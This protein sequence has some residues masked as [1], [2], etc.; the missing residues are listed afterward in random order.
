MLTTRIKQGSYD[1]MIATLCHNCAVKYA[2]FVNVPI[3][4]CSDKLRQFSGTWH[5]QELFFAVVHQGYKIV[6][7]YHSI[8]W[9]KYSSTVAQNLIKILMKWKI[10]SSKIP[11]EITDLNK[12]AKDL[13]KRTNLDICESDLVP[14]G[15][16]QTVAKNLANNWVGKNAQRVNLSKKT[17]VYTLQQ[18]GQIQ[19]KTSST[20][21]Y[22]E[23]VSPE[24]LLVHEQPDESKLASFTS[25]SL[26][27]TS[28]CNALSRM[29]LV[30]TI[31]ILEK[32]HIMV[33]YCDTDSI[34]GITLSHKTLP[35]HQLVNIDSVAIGLWKV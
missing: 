17:L 20:I 22:F 1:V 12:Y 35:I 25:G 24:C 4:D 16:L 8:F 33:L 32:N 29:H 19:S 28:L 10:C 34:Y 5:S 31:D 27:V 2:D 3:C 14:N 11:S 23:V 6:H 18:F 26:F 7:I 13:S 15:V 30:R 21:S 9:L